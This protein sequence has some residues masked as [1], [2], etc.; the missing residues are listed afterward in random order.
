MVGAEALGWQHPCAWHG[1]SCGLDSYRE[2]ND[3]TLAK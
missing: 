3:L 2:E 1:V